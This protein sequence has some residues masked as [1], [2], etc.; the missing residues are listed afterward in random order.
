ML[1]KET[2]K[3]RKAVRTAVADYM[4]SEGCGCCEDTDKHQK[5]KALLGKLLRVP[6]FPDKSGYDFYRFCSNRKR[7]EKEG[8]E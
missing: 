2:L 5:V 6:M 4:R 3:F 8:D 1:S 7:C